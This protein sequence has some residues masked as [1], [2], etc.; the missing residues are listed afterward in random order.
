[1]IIDIHNHLGKSEDGAESTFDALF[2]NMARYHI[3]RAVL[4]AI[5]EEDRGPTY[6]NSNTKILE[7]AEKYP[8]RIIPFARIVPS[9]G[10][11]A[12]E[13]FRRCLERG[14]KGLK[15]KALDNF[16][17]EQASIVI[18]LIKDRTK[19]PIIIHTSHTKES[20]PKIWEPLFKMY[21][22]NSFIL[23]HGG[24]DCYKEC[25]YILSEYPNV[26]TDTTTLSYNRTR[27]IYE[28]VGAEKILFA[29][30]YPYSH[31]AVEL[32][33]FEVLISD[34]RELTKILYQNAMKL[35]DI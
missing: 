34:K 3:T 27:H 9:I 24:K 28:T 22:N 31:P 15:L 33:K 20:Q 16:K 11:P 7:T 2:A 25:A 19:F 5:D 1:M 13:E 10:Q 26:Y 17:P 4:F 14:V 32:K 18:D 23:A 29:S 12:V 6:E 21:P 8:D 30:D 35:L